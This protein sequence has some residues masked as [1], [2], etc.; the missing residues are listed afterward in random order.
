LF[1]FNGVLLPIA[2]LLLWFPRDVA[3]PG[4]LVSTG[5]FPLSVLHLTLEWISWKGAKFVAGFAQ[6]HDRVDPAA[7]KR[8]VVGTVAHATCK[9]CLHEDGG[10]QVTHPVVFVV[11]A[12]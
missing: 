8:A 4:V 10:P 12:W 3:L 7:N 9:I 2:V 5:K 11:I 1:N 6:P